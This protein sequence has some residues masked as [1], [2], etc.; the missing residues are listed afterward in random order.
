V[1]TALYIV[2]LHLLVRVFMGT[3]VPGRAPPPSHASPLQ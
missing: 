2:L 3:T 1:F